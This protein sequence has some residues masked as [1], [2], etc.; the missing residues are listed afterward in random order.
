MSSKT[1][2]GLKRLAIFPITTETDSTVTYG[3]TLSIQKKLMTAKS[4]PKTSEAQLEA[5]NQIVDAVS[6]TDGYDIE[7]GVTDLESSERVT[8]YGETV[9]GGTNVTS[10][11]SVGTYVGVAYMTTRAD[12]L[13]N[14]YKYPKVIFSQSEE[15]VETKKQGT[16]NYQTLTLKGKT[17]PLLSDKTTRYVRYGVDPSTDSAIIESWFSTADYYKPATTP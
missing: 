2:I 17:M 7:I 8:I 11:D 15:S 10:I 3:T 14:L 13:V 6:T 4:T 16:V 5:D 9:D 12:G 1:A